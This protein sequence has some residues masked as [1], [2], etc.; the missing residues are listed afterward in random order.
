MGAIILG[1]IVLAAVVAWI[2]WPSDHEIMAEERRK[3]P[4][5]YHW[6]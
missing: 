5:R 4:R 6:K 1:L 2:F 3:R